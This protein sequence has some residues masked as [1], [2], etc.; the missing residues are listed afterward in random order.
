[1]IDHYVAVVD[2]LI[3]LLLL[4]WSYMDRKQIYLKNKS[5]RRKNGTK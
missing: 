5:A 3:L 1:M 4:C 2:T